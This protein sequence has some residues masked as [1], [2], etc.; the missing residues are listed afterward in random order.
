MAKKRDVEMQLERLQTQVEGLQKELTNYR[1]KEFAIV[2]ALTDAQETSNRRIAEAQTEADRILVEARGKADS[3]VAEA[4]QA[5]TGLEEETAARSKAIISEAEENWSNSCWEKLS[6][7]SN[8][9]RRTSREKPAPTRGAIKPIS[10]AAA[11]PRSVIRS[12]S[13]PILRI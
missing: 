13:S 11:P 3:I 2:H 12:I 10:T 1:A 7:F 6:T 5:K 8:K 4:E 9:S